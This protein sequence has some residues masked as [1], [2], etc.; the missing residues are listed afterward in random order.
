MFHTHTHKNHVRFVSTNEAMKCMN[1]SRI[2]HV[3][4]SQ[5]KC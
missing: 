3:G 2:I 1:C 5:I 4:A